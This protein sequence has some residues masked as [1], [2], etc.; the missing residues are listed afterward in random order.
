MREDSGR[1]YERAFEAW[2]VDRRV[3]FVR[4][5]GPHRP[6]AFGVSVK[7]FDFLIRTPDRRQVIAEVK[8]R[9]YKGTSLARL[10]G[11]DC[12]V[13]LDDVH[14]LNLW[15]RALGANCVAAFIFA[16]RVAQ[17]DVDCDGRE[18]F[19]FETDRYLFFAIRAADYHECMRRRSPRWKTVTLAAE[20]F[21]RYAVNPMDLLVNPAGQD[22]R[23]GR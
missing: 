16:Y 18:L 22:L 6:A 7:S 12:W 15:Q 14:G 19:P 9:T 2:L 1:S 10:K 8:G 3:A 21:R 20:H 17:V 23:K 11:L 13:T 4:A 5:D